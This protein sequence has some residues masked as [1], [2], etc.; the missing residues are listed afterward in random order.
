MMRLVVLLAMSLGALVACGGS[1]PSVDVVADTT[2]PDAV[3]TVEPDPGQPGDVGAGDGHSD[4]GRDIGIDSIGD[5]GQGDDVPDA[6]DSVQDTEY[7]DQS[8]DPGEDVPDPT[9][10][11]DSTEPDQIRQPSPHGRVQ[12]AVYKAGSSYNDRAQ[13]DVELYDLPMRMDAFGAYSPEMYQV[14]LAEGDCVQYFP[15]E[16]ACNPPCDW[17][18]LCVS[19][20]RCQA[21]ASRQSAGDMTLR[22]G[23]T[24]FESKPTGT[25][26]NPYWY[27][28]DNVDAGLV[29]PATTVTVAADGFDGR[30]GA[31]EIP[32]GGVGPA[33]FFLDDEWGTLD[34]DDENGNEITW[35]VPKG[36]LNGMVVEVTI[37]TGWHGAPPAAVIYCVKPVSA[38]SLTIPA[39]IAKQ[40]P[41]M[42][43]IG[44]F[45]HMSG[46]AMSRSGFADVQ[47]RTVQLHVARLHNLN[48]T[49]NLEG[50]L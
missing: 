23:S 27:S 19:G 31:F 8:G 21:A 35:T 12:V 42:G 40:M 22:F 32:V 33:E 4:L 2:A 46:I 3:D 48:V 29:D 7:L 45:Q 20:N 17:D 10:A 13:V 5:G 25:E 44:L 30:Y 37:N 49:H 28:F 16:Y 34:L 18:K 39:S 14:W 1:D 36:D 24:S 43:G 38:G 50:D 47:G 9:D 15:V 6:S 26:D 11:G 41:P